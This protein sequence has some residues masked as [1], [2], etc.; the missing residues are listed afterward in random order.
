MKKKFAAITFAIILLALLTSSLFAAGAHEFEVLKL[1]AYIP[2]KTTFRAG[3]M[4]FQIASNAYNFTYSIADQGMI[5][6]LFVVAN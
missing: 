5:R 4:G 2:E 1:N 6:T 3:D